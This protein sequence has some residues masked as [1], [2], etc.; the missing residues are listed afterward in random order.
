[1]VKCS[2]LTEKAKSFVSIDMLYLFIFYRV[3]SLALPSIFF[4]MSMLLV[5]FCEILIH[6]VMLVLNCY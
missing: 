2:F 4:K 1:M 5:S 3:M 6:S